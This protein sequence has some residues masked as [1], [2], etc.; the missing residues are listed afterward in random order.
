MNK[1]TVK[2]DGVEYTI[3]GEK[4]E[5]EIVKVAKFIDGELQQISKAAPS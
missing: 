5:A 1:V 2:I 4:N 3:V